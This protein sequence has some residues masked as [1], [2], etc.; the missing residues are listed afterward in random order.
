MGAAAIALTTTPPCSEGV[1]RDVMKQPIT[2]S[3]GVNRGVPQGGGSRVE[4]PREEKGSDQN[5]KARR[6]IGEAF[7]QVARRRTK[8]R[9]QD[10]NWFEHVHEGRV[11]QGAFQTGVCAICRGLARR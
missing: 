2:V 3:E 11:E 4:E 8:Q 7:G 9:T 5:Q 10:E 1:R 6:S